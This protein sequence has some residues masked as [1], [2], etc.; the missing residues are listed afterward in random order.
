MIRSTQARHDAKTP[1]AR[2]KLWAPQA[3]KQGVQPRF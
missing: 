1:E 2:V 3:H